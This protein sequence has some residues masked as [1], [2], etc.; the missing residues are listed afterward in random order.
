MKSIKM[1]PKIWE[2]IDLRSP[3]L[4]LAYIRLL[5]L[6]A[7]SKGK[8]YL[9]DFH[10]DLLEISPRWPVLVIDELCKSKLIEISKDGM[11]TVVDYEKV[12][13]AKKE[14][15]STEMF[16][17]VVDAW[18]SMNIPSIGQVS[19]ITKT[20][21]RG[22]WLAARIKEY[23]VDDILKA[24]E[25]VKTSDFLK[26]RNN[27]GWTITFDWF[28]RPNNFPKVLEGNYNHNRNANEKPVPQK[29]QS[30]F[31]AL[32]DDIAKDMEKRGVINHTSGNIDYSKANERDIGNLKKYGI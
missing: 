18:N 3:S 15:V 1:S 2:K 27:A 11:I 4:S 8:V 10:N 23:G 28:I 31:A 6:I 17:V 16:D 9:E 7:D 29:P 22:K 19:R 5:F 32:P 13:G 14:A 25:N 21:Q 12:V 20:G 26:G 30:R 24:I